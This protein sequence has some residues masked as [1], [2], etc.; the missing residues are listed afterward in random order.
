VQVPERK[1]FEPVYLG[2]STSQTL[3]RSIEVKTKQFLTTESI[4]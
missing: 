2:F 3:S 1:I 4:T